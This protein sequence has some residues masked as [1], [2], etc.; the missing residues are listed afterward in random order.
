MNLDEQLR[1]ALDR[2]AEMQKG[3]APDVDRLINGGKVRRRRRNVVRFGVAAAL[4]VVLMAVGLESQG[5]LSWNPAPA[6]P[7]STVQALGSLGRL[8][9]GIDGDIY[10]ADADGRNPVRVADGAP[11]KEGFCGGYW[12][13]GPLW[14]PD[15]RYLAYRGDGGEAIPGTCDRTVNISDAAGH[16][17]ASF[18]GEGWSIA[19]SPDSTR[20]A[21]WDDFYGAAKL[22]IYGL[23][24]QRQAL[25]DMPPGW[26]PPGD[27]DPVWSRDGASLLVPEGAEVPVDGSTPKHVS[28]NDPRSQLTTTYSPNGAE[29]AYISTEGLVVAA[30]NG[31]QA[32]VLVPGR[33]QDFQGFPWSL[34]W[35]PTGD[36]IAY[37]SQTSGDS[38]EAGRRATELVVLD[39]A[40]AS[41]VPLAELGGANG[42]K[43]IKFSPEGD[44]LLFTRTEA[45][46]SSLWSV[47]VDGS[48]P[49]RLVAGTGWGDW[50]QR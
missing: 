7:A 27:V 28:G 14:S 20:V 25:L 1:A 6:D 46:A 30:A 2:E 48:D 13:E 49:H 50:Q 29:I 16:R 4:A 8:A 41:V 33:L 38:R 3:P 9:Y 34:V 45:R 23:D 35:S 21:V 11:S 26:A 42:I 47:D 44:Q 10:V 5:R 32:R 19:W 36:R 15:G 37:I 12:G 31:S 17:V 22:A 40:S 43:V 39:V 24:G 18:P